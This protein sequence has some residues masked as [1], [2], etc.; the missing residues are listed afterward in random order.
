MEGKSKTFTNLEEN[1]HELP[2]PE[3]RT[4][5]TRLEEWLRQGEDEGDKRAWGI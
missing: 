4:R 5:R 1:G 2:T 3:P